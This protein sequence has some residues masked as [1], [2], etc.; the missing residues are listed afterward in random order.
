MG[1][2]V[3]NSQSQKK[4]V[5]EPLEA[6]QVKM[7]CCGPTVYDY[8]HVGNFRGAVFYNFVRNW[9]EKQGYQVT[10]VYNFT[11]VDDKILKRAQDEGKTAQEISEKYIEE[12]WKDFLAL[13]L[14]PHSQN[15]KVTEHMQDIVS[16]IEEIIKNG[17]AYVV[18][19][20]VFYSI[21]NFPEYGKLSHRNPDDMQSGARIEVDPKKRNPLDFTLWKPAKPGEQSWPS[22]WGEGR[23]GWHIECSAMNRALLGEQIDIHG[24]G[25]DLIFPHH[26]NEIAQSEGATGKPYVRYWLHNNMFTFSGAKMS[27]SLGNIR[28]MRSFLE[29]FNGEIFKY[30]VLSVHYRSE[31]EFS[32][33]TINNSVAALGRI[34]SALAKAKEYAGGDAH[35]KSPE[36]TKMQEQ[37]DQAHVQMEKFFNDDFA[38]PQAMAQL[39]DTIRLFNQLVPAGAKKKGPNQRI[40][41]IFFDFVTGFGQPMALFQEEPREFLQTL[42]QML[43]RLKG[44]DKAKVI[45]LLEKRGWARQEK[46]F[47][48]SD[49]LRDELNSMG[50]EIR[51]TAQ[52]TEWEVHKGNS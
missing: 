39:F 41:Q 37:V 12:F 42:D 26:E 31:A 6:G 23:P 25:M 47:A 19:G 11:D 48:E 35:L 13:H 1:L 38:T 15:P 9:L 3:Y 16:L 14:T 40:A 30:L 52:G 46:N 44:I 24:G 32:D 4:E 28:T 45:E 21:E 17:K 8:L 22:P 51:D 5:F 29:Q 34:Y 7:Y 43:L 33:V 49:R 10:Y 20:E 36:I 27:K 50:I 18:D 2:Q